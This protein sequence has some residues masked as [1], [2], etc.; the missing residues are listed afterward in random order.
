MK[1]QVMESNKIDFS[2]VD[3]GDFISFTSGGERNVGMLVHVKDDE[4]RFLNTETG[5]TGS[6]SGKTVV[7]L[8]K[9]YTHFKNFRHYSRKEYTLSIILEETK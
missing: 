4:Y 9:D 5:L 1:F 6:N 2:K 3:V 8:I 7:S